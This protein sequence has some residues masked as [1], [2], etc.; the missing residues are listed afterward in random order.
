M[1][2]PEANLAAVELETEKMVV[3]GQVV[4]GVSVDDL[5]VGMEMELVLGTL[6]EDDENEYMVWKWQPAAQA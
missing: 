5:K 1:E 3:L 6:Y 2:V 4:A